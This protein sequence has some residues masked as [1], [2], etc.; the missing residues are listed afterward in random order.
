MHVLG[1]IQHD[2][3]YIDNASYAKCSVIRLMRT[4]HVQQN[5]SQ[6]AYVSDH[7]LYARIHVLVFKTPLEYTYLLLSVLQGCDVSSC[8]Q[9]AC[10]QCTQP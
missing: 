2:E 10:V 6:W 5:I 4:I 7:I 8:P 9:A 1:M 3:L